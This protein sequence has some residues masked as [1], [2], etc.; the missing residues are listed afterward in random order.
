MKNVT[1]VAK[2]DLNTCTGCKTCEK[3]CPVL[4]IKIIDRKAIIDEDKCRGCS[5]CESRCP[6][7]SIEMVKREEP[8]VVGIDV[9]K[10]D[11]EKI[12]EICMNA[13]MNPEQILC[14]CTGVRA[15]EV[16]AAILDGARTPEEISSRTG[17][18]TGCT[19]E[20]IQ[21]LLRIIHAAGIELKP[22]EGGWQWYGIT[23]TSW[24]LTDEVKEKYANKGFYFDEDK[25]L[26]ERVAS[27]RKEKGE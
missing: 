4:A 27:A 18:R 2:V 1:L 16:A 14:Y 3:I 15:E 21:P 10:F 19:I 6:V 23:P 12:E 20:C 13:H 24:D 11:K 8:F 26:F 9:E 17:I 7:H 25:E 5:N 22:I